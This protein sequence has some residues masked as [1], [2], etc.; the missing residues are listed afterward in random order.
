MCRPIGIVF[1]N[2]FGT[3]L[4]QRVSV[5]DQ[6]GSHEFTAVYSVNLVADEY[7]LDK[8]VVEDT[9]AYYDIDDD[10]DWVCVDFTE[11]TAP[12]LFSR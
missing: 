2:D 4:T 6:D 10:L 9:P 1:E 7:G 11:N 8:I 5:S 3:F 12:K